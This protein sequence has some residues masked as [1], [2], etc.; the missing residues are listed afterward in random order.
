M[1]PEKR[2]QALF[3]AIYRLFRPLVRLLL[4][5]GIPFGVFADI[6]KRAYLDVA[7]REFGVDGRKQTDSRVATITGL[8]RKE[9]AR[10]K[11]HL[12]E[13]DDH[14]VVEKYNRAAR[15]VFGWVHDKT[16]CSESGDTRAL[17]FEGGESNISTLVK[18]YSGDMPPRA[19]LDELLRVGVVEQ[20]QDG[21]YRL[22][23]RAYIP[24]KSDIEKLR[25]LGQDVAGLISTIDRNI[26]NTEQDRFFQRKIY[27]DNLP[28][29]AIEPLR[30]ML[31]EQGQQFLETVDQW[32]AKHDRDI[33]PEAGGT[34]RKAAGIGLFYFQEDD[35]NEEK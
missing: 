8:T 4:R 31:A 21:L 14:T 9:V 22:R 32:M 1:N 28:A 25:I 12:E 6:A 10:L 20:Q 30:K 5:N 11:H 23:E 29:E 24:D 19:I 34:G 15:V 7:F 3:R 18:T 13:P 26:H 35:S 33:N 2:Q 17:P 27:Y 16:Y